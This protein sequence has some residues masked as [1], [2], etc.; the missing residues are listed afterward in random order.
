MVKQLA[1]LAATA[2]LAGKDFVGLQ[3]VQLILHIYWC[4]GNSLACLNRAI[5]SLDRPF[6]KNFR[7][8]RLRGGADLAHLGAPRCA[9]YVNWQ[10]HP[11]AINCQSLS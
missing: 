6:V 9:L 2:N 4:F 10:L 1:V 8:A 3:V 11:N 5:F 7:L